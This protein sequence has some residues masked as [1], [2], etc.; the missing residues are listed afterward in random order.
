MASSAV[1]QVIGEPKNYKKTRY[2]YE[3]EPCEALLAATAVADITGG[4]VILLAPESLVT[5]LEPD[6]DEACKLLENPK[7]FEQ[8]VLEQLDNGSE[9]HP[10]TTVEILPSVGS[11]R[12]REKDWRINAQGTFAAIEA[13]LFLIMKKLVKEGRNITMVVTSGLN[14]Y[15]A[16]A[17]RTLYNILTYQLLAAYPHEPNPR[18]CHKI[19][20]HTIPTQENEEIR[21]ETQAVET[22]IYNA[23]PL[24]NEEIND[25]GTVYRGGL[26]GNLVRCLKNGLKAFICINRNTPLP[27]YHEQI[28]EEISQEC[29]EKLEQQVA[30]DLRKRIEHTVEKE[31]VQITIKRS[32]EN[33]PISFIRRTMMALAMTK[34]LMKLVKEARKNMVNGFVP[35]DAI[36]TLFIE[37]IYQNRPHFTHNRHLLESEVENIEKL[38]DR[39]GETEQYLMNFLSGGKGSSDMVRNFFAHSGFLGDITYV[40]K[41]SSSRI[42]LRYDSERAKDVGEWLLGR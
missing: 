15:P 19:V 40:K 24:T 3:N 1:L 33:L 17:L 25:L 39:L 2:V 21:I 20:Y 35:L 22:T 27:L 36:K 38:R 28:I 5:S 26:R 42:L 32:T 34:S 8:K 14:I 7:M 4:E 29:V 6:I 18:P 9:N 10:K 16:L 31:K 11:F 23:F 37:E 12:Q 13:A 41:D 30:D